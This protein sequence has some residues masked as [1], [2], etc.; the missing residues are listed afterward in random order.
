M[1]FLKLLYHSIDLVSH[2]NIPNCVTAPITLNFL[3]NFFFRTTFA[4][5]PAATLAA[6][7][8]AEDLPPPL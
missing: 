4:I 6:V 5:A 2:P 8:L 3:P 1:D 7:S